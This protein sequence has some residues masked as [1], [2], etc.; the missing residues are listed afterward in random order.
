[1][2]VSFSVAQ[3]GQLLGKMMVLVDNSVKQGDNG[4]ESIWPDPPIGYENKSLAETGDVTLA[5][6]IL[7]TRYGEPMAERSGEALSQFFRCPHNGA[8]F[9]EGNIL[10][11][12]RT[13]GEATKTAISVEKQLF[14]PVELQC[15]LC[16][17][18]NFRHRFNIFRP[19]IDDSQP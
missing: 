16:F 6:L 14:R 4:R 11:I 18:N 3:R 19:W 8:E 15:L 12:D 13:A 1:M 5:Y 17:G 10:D 2:L 9:L 7:S